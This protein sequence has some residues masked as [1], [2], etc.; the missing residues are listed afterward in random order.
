[1]VV[2]LNETTQPQGRTLPLLLTVMTIVMMVD[3]V[4]EVICAVCLLT[5]S[6]L[7]LLLTTTDYCSV[8]PV[9]VATSP[10]FK[11]VYIPILRADYNCMDTYTEQ[12]G[13][14]QTRTG[15]AP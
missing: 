7:F 14:L 15:I 2:V 1:M 10:D 8:A 9:A 4:W 12:Q 6:P 5:S 13:K 3:M 11:V